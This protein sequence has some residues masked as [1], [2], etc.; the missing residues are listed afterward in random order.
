MKGVASQSNM[1]QI[2]SSLPGVKL[3]GKDEIT[4]EKKYRK[5]RNFLQLFTQIG[6]TMTPLDQQTCASAH[7]LL[8]FFMI[9]SVFNPSISS[10]ASETLMLFIHSSLVKSSAA[11]QSH[12]KMASMEMSPAP[13]RQSQAISNRN[14]LDRRKRDGWRRNV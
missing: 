12:L 13:L 1:T 7:C 6:I 4:M 8:I 9:I 11:F 10:Q 2:I 14:A 5:Q 3:G